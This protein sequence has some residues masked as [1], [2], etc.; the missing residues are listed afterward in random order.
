MR[1]RRQDSHDK[2][3]DCGGG[4]HGNDTCSGNPCLNVTNSRFQDQFVVL[5][6]I[7]PA[8]YNCGSNCWWKVRYTP[9][10]NTTVTDRTT[11]SVKVLG[12]PVHLIE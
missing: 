7:L 8:N 5:S 10:T 1:Q 3:N 6:Y 9:Q 12:G 11:W 2:R 4:D